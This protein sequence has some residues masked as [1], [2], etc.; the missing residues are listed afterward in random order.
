M[1]HFGGI[2]G[3]A[4][5]QHYIMMDMT[6]TYD[7]MDKDGHVKTLPLFAAD[8]SNLHHHYIQVSNPRQPLTTTTTIL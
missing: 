6:R 7:T 4:I 5:R 2:K 3:Q 8:V 1:I